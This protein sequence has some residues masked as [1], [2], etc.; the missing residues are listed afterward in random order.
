MF[1]KGLCTKVIGIL[2]LVKAGVFSFAAPASAQKFIMAGPRAGGHISNFKG[3]GTPYVSPIPGLQGG[4]F[5]SYTTH[6]HI[7]VMAEA[8]YIS[9]GGRDARVTGREIIQRVNYLE[10]PV[11]VHYYFAQPEASTRYYLFAGPAISFRLRGRLREGGEP[12]RINTYD[13]RGSD[14]GLM[15][16]GGK[17]IR[18]SDKHYVN[19]ALRYNWGFTEIYDFNMIGI[20]NISNQVLSIAVYKGFVIVNERQPPV[21]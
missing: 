20:N 19:V 17:T 10:L 13:F 14:L 9:K 2:L 11:M 12:T 5:I 1:K 4:L 8:N 16:G 3:V 18:L 15:I 7:S 21:K 6:R